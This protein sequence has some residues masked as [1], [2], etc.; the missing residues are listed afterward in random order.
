MFRGGGGAKPAWSREL[1]GA[2]TES[3]VAVVVL[4]V[5][6]NFENWRGG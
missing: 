4:G 3:D 2:A 5:E 1:S 6:M